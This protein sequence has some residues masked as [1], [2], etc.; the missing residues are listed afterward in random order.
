MLRYI[1]TIS[2][3]SALTWFIPLSNAQANLSPVVSWPQGALSLSEPG[4]FC[5]LTNGAF[6]QFDGSGSVNYYT[7]EGSALWYVFIISRISVLPS[8]T[9]RLT[10]FSI[11]NII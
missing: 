7:A 10:L 8:I 4:S 6:G 1:S 2:I 3:V 11:M 9:L 5:E